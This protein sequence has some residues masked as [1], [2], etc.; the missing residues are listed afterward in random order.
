MKI[1]YTRDHD[2]PDEDTRGDPTSGQMARFFYDYRPVHDS[3]GVPVLEADGKPKMNRILLVEFSTAHDACAKPV[4]KV[5][6]VH[7]V[8]YKRFWDAFTRQ[9]DF[10]QHVGTPLNCLNDLDI[11]Q[12]YQIQGM[13]ILSIEQL[14]DAH[15]GLL[16]QHPWLRHWK[17]KAQGYLIEHKPKPDAKVL[18][19]LAEL[20]AQLEQMKKEREPLVQMIPP[21]EKKKREYRRQ[22]EAASGKPNVLKP[23]ETVELEKELSE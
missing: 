21:E 6:E 7:K 14:A 19:E 11:I 9:E 18:G 17:N 10:T 4:S 22:A 13:S 12:Q 16:L 15:E 1:G 2:H 8:M 23:H 3:A 20:R 5:T